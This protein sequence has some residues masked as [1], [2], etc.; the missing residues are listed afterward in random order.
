[1]YQSRVFLEVRILVS[2]TE[3][4]FCGCHI[5]AKAGTCPCC[6]RTFTNL[7]RHMASKHKDVGAE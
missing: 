6:N 5:G 1:M 7:A 3:K 2:T 4:A